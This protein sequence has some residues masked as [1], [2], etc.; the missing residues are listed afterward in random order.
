VAEPRRALGEPRPVLQCES[1]KSGR[2]Q[3]WQMSTFSEPGRPA[4]SRQVDP[5][6]PT[7]WLELRVRDGGRVVAMR[8]GASRQLRKISAVL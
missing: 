1:C 2:A 6:H 7:L 3:E 5:A 8:A 4:R